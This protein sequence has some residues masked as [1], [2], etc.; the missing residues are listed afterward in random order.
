M[1]YRS[2]QIIDRFLYEKNKDRLS[3]R[4]EKRKAQHMKE[5]SFALGWPDRWIKK[6]SS[7]VFIALSGLIITAIAA[8]FFPKIYYPFGNRSL[9]YVIGRL[10]NTKNSA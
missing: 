9:D 10:V 7:P 8:Y 2:Y 1:T 5:I 6:F 4:R 3:K